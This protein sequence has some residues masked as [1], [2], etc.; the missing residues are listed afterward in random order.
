MEFMKM[1]NKTAKKMDA[2]VISVLRLFRQIFRHDNLN[3]IL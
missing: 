3:N 1:E 2:A